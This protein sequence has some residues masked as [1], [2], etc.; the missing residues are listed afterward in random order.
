MADDKK[1]KEKSGPSLAS[2]FIA[3]FILLFIFWI[4]TGG[5]ERHPES[6]RNYFI[7]TNFNTYR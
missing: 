7:N 2:W 6:R 1:P 3:V 4:I 5:P